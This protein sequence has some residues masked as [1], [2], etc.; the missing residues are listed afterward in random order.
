MAVRLEDAKIKVTLATGDA[1]QNL[2]GLDSQEKMLKEELALT[3]A[4]VS[5]TR[6]ELWTAAQEDKK[7]R[8]E[9]GPTPTLDRWNR[10]MSRVASAMRNPLEEM[11]QVAGVFPPAKWAIEAIRGGSKLV[12]KGPEFAAFL[13]GFFD[14]NDPLARRIIDRIAKQVTSAKAYEEAIGPASQK[15]FEMNEA[16]LRLGGTLPQSEMRLW[17]T[18]L[19]G[20]QRQIEMEKRIRGRIRQDSFRALARVMRGNNATGRQ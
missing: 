16:F 10:N 12:E 8:M 4:R 11:E 9:Q 6:H 1:A 14:S 2:R 17:N 18:I 15:F 19:Q 7:K 5:Q 13:E 20:E 3:K